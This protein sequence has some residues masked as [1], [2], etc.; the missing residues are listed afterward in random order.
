M[1]PDQCRLEH[2]PGERPEVR[3]CSKPGV[4]DAN[5]ACIQSFWCHDSDSDKNAGHQTWIPFAGARCPLGCFRAMTQAVKP[6]AP[7]TTAEYRNEWKMSNECW[8]PGSSA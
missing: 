8:P 1:V 5:Q 7:S 2:D 3:R 6:S 4:A